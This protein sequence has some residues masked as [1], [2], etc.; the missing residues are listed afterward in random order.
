MPKVT[1]VGSINIDFLI[2]T[3]RI[4]KKGETVEGESFSTNFG[5]KGANQ[6]VSAAKLGA[7]V[8]MIGAVGEDEFGQALIDNLKKYNINTDYIKVKP[9]EP[10]GAAFI[11]LYKGDNS[12]I[13]V[14]GANSAVSYQDVREAENVLLTS[15]IV[16]VQNE[17][18][19]ETVEYLVDF[20]YKR[21]ITILL[22]PAPA[23]PI[24]KEYIDKLNFFTP[25]ETEFSVIFGDKKVEDV[26][27]MYPNKIIITLGS[28]GAM[29]HDGEKMVHIPA[30]EVDEIVDTTGA[31]DT[32]NGAFAY[33]QQSSLTIEEAV[34]FANLTS[35]V[36]IQKFGAQTGAPSFEEIQALKEYENS[37][38]FKN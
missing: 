4:A 2:Q 6:A 7:Q 34:T 20:C 28:E 19:R 23:R 21:D 5:G 38:G 11:R 22:N 35:S 37:W 36:S 30:L 3:N 14:P 13:Y 9:G 33:A 10:S 25:N 16:I 32:F 26:L 18:P 15:D 31:G 1:V 27:S 29:F 17:L 8:H 12:I 24:S